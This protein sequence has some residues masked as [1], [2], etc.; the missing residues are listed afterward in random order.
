MLAAAIPHVE[1]AFRG[2]LIAQFAK[3][4]HVSCDSVVKIHG[5][6]SGFHPTT[7]AIP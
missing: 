6:L 4:V 1:E 3:A 2:V 5:W 7:F